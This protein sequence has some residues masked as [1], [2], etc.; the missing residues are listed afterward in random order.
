MTSFRNVWV[1]WI[2]LFWG[3]IALPLE[4]QTS[5]TNQA[6]ISYPSASVTFE[7][8]ERSEK[9]SERFLQEV[10]ASDSI[11][12]D[13]FTGPSS[14]LSWA[15]RKDKLGY[16]SLD[17]WN[18]DGAKLFTT[19]ATDSLRTA[20][21]EALPLDNWQNYWEGRFA[22][23]IAGT[24][25]NPLEEHIE[26]AS[27]S[28][29]AVRSS[30]ERENEKGGVQWG[31]RPW[32]TSPYVY[33]FAHAG[34]LDGKPLLTFEGR[35]GYTFFASTRLEGR[36][37][38]QLPASFRLAGGAGVD[39]GKLGTRDTSASFY[40]FSLERL[41]QVRDHIPAGIFYLGFRSGAYGGSSNQ[42]HENMIVA[43]LSRPW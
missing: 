26:V 27:V 3:V 30:W 15:R 31:L 32:R 36:L 39:P 17:Q 35:A 8:T 38:L 21:I 1:S 37:T 2:V 34:H 6:A 24:L 40:G 16:A 5:K 33:L 29:S 41:V 22:G 9:L 28:Y 23:F 43:G 13:R 19:I 18:A 42:R 10:V 12:F 4:A 20:A 11:V 7:P 14:R 25:G